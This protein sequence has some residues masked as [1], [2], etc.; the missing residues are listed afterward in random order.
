MKKKEII[1]NAEKDIYLTATVT[2]NHL[3][4][5]LRLPPD[6][7]K[8]LKITKENKKIRI[9]IN[10]DNMLIIEKATDITFRELSVYDKCLQIQKCYALSSPQK[11]LEKD[12]I[13]SISEYYNITTRTVYRYL[14]ELVLQDDLKNVKLLPKQNKDYR[15]INIMFSDSDSGSEQTF[16]TIP[17]IFS[18]KFLTGKSYEELKI[19]SAYDLFKSKFRIKGKIK[20][21]GKEQ[22]ILVIKGI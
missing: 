2:N 4:L 3:N 1:I 21:M 13:E 11:T 20:Y 14:K 8:L 19:K 6:W 22:L 15:N 16:I 10:K 17:T 7:I 5:K 12:V 18:I 9:S